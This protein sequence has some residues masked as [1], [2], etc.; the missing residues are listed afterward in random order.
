MVFTLYL[1]SV[2]SDDFLDG[3]RRTGEAIVTRAITTIPE[4]AWV[5]IHYPNAIFDEDGQRWISDAEVARSP[6]PAFANRRKREHVTARLIVRRVRRL[7]QT[8][9]PA[10]HAAPR[11]HAS[12]CS[13]TSA[14]R[15]RW[16]RSCACS[17]RPR[18]PEARRRRR[19]AAG[20]ARRRT[21]RPWGSVG[22]RAASGPSSPA[23]YWQYL[24]S[25]VR[26]VVSLNAVSAVLAS[27]GEPPPPSY[28]LVVSAGTVDTSLGRGCEFG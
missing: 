22:A 27:E 25:N 11:R 2:L 14:H 19:P 26:Q 17:L 16:A 4:T 13:P 23:S 20:P 6:S 3:E 8:M 5:P 7:N 24:P 12:G 21:P 28:L 15:R 18:P 10:G 1:R 9:A